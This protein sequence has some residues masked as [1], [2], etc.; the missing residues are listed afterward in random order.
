VK[1]SKL[2]IT[3]DKLWEYVKNELTDYFTSSKSSLHDQLIPSSILHGY[4]N[5]M[6]ISKPRNVLDE[7]DATDGIDDS[8]AQSEEYKFSDKELI[9]YI[10]P[11]RYCKF[12]NIG[13][14]YDKLPD[15]LSNYSLN[16]PISMTD[17][18]E[19]YSN[20]SNIISDLEKQLKSLN[21]SSPIEELLKQRL[22]ERNSIIYTY[23]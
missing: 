6:E 17:Y 22:I 10:E 3:S 14:P 7:I 18:V 11:E 5:Q 16:T 13:I 20:S 2:T 8:G 9:K 21:T 23:T 4:G 1:D 12:N 19:A 15:K